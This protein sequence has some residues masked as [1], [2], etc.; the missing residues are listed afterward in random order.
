[1]RPIGSGLEGAVRDLPWVVG[2]IY[3][4][5]VGTGMGTTLYVSVWVGEERGTILCGIWGTGV[6]V[7]GG[8]R[9]RILVDPLLGILHFLVLEDICI[10]G[11]KKPGDVMIDNRCEGGRVGGVCRIAVQFRA[12]VDWGDGKRDCSEAFVVSHSVV[13]VPAVSAN[14][15]NGPT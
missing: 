2:G 4:V 14:D 6:P 5:G 15:V 11:F 8:E 7:L 12:G 9:S 13:V 10:S 1:M 3:P